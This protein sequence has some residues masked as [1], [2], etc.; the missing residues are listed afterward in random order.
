[1]CSFSPA[2]TLL[3]TLL[4]IAAADTIYLQQFPVNPV[5]ALL[6]ETRLKRLAALLEERFVPK[7]EL[8]LKARLCEV[9]L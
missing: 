1:M 2:S 3:L 5:L 9:Y 6:V 7:Q 4:A 8:Y